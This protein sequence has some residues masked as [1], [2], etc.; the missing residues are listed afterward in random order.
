MAA[1]GVHTNTRSRR[2]RRGGRRCCARCRCP[3][4][5]R[6]LEVGRAHLARVAAGQD[7]VERDEPELARMARRPGDDHAP[8]LEQRRKPAPSRTGVTE[9]SVPARRSTRSSSTSA[10]TATGLPSTMM[11]G[12]T[13]ADATSGRSRCEARR[14]RGDVAPA[15]SRSTAGSPRN[16]AEQRLGAQIVDDAR[17]RR[18]ASSGTSRNAT[19]ASAS[20][21]TPPMPEH[22]ARPELRV[23]ARARR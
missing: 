22:H 8:G 17:R 14:G 21:S 4:T 20:A 18:G 16:G 15:R 6:A 13:S 2:R 19:S 11:S 10:S 7:V 3:R 1:A 12:L 9:R 23:A 5:S